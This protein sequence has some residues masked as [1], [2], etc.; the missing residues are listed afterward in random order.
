MDFFNKKFPQLFKEQFLTKISF[1]TKKTC[2][3]NYTF[4]TLNLL[5][6]SKQ[7]YMTRDIKQYK[8]EKKKKKKTKNAEI[9]YLT[10]LAVR[11]KEARPCFAL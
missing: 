9:F 5:I 3:E 4:Y 10:Q 2:I 1:L 8:N 7:E 6:K 11:V